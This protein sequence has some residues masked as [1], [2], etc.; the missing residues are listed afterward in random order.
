MSQHIEVAQVSFL[1]VETLVHEVANRKT[2]LCFLMLKVRKWNIKIFPVGAISC[3][4]L[5]EQ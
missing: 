2:P 3:D 5:R 4:A 1:D